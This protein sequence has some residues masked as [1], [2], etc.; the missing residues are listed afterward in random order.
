[1][2][3]I[4]IFCGTKGGVPRALA[5]L[6][7]AGDR[8]PIP[9]DDRSDV[10]TRRKRTRLTAEARRAMILDI[11]CR[12]FA[13]VGYRAATTAQIAREAGVSEPVLYQHFGSKRALYIACASA[14]WDRVRVEWERAIADEESPARWPSVMANQGHAIADLWS[15]T[16]PEMAI[17]DVLR[18][19]LSDHLR[20]IHRYMAS[21]Y[22]RAQVLGGI[23]AE[24]DPGAE[25]W[26]LI[27]LA[28]LRS[29][30]APVGVVAPHLRDILVAREQWLA[31][32]SA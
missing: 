25:A 1:M 6:V 24:C 13:D 31:P 27:A 14:T 30:D 22:Q 8:S 11:A 15:R 9:I 17:D 7:R 21:I 10:A 3:A 23:R 20:E 12:I 29:L 28:L 32:A 2:L 19:F 26:T 18:E 16:L 5:L 4:T